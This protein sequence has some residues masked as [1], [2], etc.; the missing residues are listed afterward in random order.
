MLW[1]EDSKL[2]GRRAATFAAAK[3]SG[4][5]SIGAA[6][7]SFS[8]ANRLLRISVSPGGVLAVVFTSCWG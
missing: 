8:W 7:M 3:R 4:S 2:F 6:A 5:N 1:G